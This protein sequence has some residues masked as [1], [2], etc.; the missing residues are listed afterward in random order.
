MDISIVNNN[1]VVLCISM[2]SMFMSCFVYVLELLIGLRAMYNINA[3]PDIHIVPKI[4]K[5]IVD[6]M[7]YGSLINMIVNPIVS[8]KVIASIIIPF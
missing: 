7:S 6:C 4:I 5:V 3:V 8:I 2:I 1:I